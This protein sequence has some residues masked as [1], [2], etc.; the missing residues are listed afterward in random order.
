MKNYFTAW[1]LIAIG[2]L[3]ISGE[4]RAAT[5]SEQYM[6]SELCGK[7]SGEYWLE[8]K[9]GIP[10]NAISRYTNHY[11][12]KDNKCYFVMKY[13]AQLTNKTTIASMTVFNLNDHKIIAGYASLGEGKTNMCE[14]LDKQCSSAAEWEK[15][16]QPYLDD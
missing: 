7:R 6:L 14:V 4:G 12:L 5:A 9:K 11:N 8:E 2:T 1:L 16:V 13:A 15:L 3:A 10:L